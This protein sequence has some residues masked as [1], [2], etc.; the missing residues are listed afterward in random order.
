VYPPE[1]DA[2][3]QASLVLP[4]LADLTAEAI[5]ALAWKHMDAAATPYDQGGLTAT[6]GDG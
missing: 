3:A 2:L 6:S 5:A 4:T 1:P